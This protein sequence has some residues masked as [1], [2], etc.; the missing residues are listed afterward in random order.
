M[1]PGEI[2]KRSTESFSSHPDVSFIIQQSKKNL[3]RYKTLYPSENS[4]Y[5]TG[6]NGEISDPFKKLISGFTTST[7][8]VTFKKEIFI[9]C[10]GFNEEFRFSEDTLLFHQ[11]MEHG[12]VFCI[13]EVLGTHR[14][15]E[16]SIVSTYLHGR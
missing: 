3:H 13:D 12:N 14:I 9:K 4:S 15:H 7:S 5:G 6:K 11:L 8:A 2:G 16:S 10:G 1:V